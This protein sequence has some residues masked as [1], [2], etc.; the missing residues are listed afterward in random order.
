MDGHR[1]VAIF[2]ATISKLRGRRQRE[3]AEVIQIELNFIILLLL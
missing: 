1:R 3:R 2:P